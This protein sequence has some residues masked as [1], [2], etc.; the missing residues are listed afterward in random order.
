MIDV[1]EDEIL[2]LRAQ[3]MANDVGL[4]DLVEQARRANEHRS[5]RQRLDLEA[6]FRAMPGTGD[7]HRTR[8]APGS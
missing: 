3:L 5:E 7:D 8:A 6:A 4:M 1:I 2:A